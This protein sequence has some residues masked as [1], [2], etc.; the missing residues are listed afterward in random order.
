MMGQAYGVILY[1]GEAQQLAEVGF[2]REKLARYI[3][4]YKAIPWEEFDEDTQ[5]KIREIAE[6]GI[7]PGLTLDNCQPGGKIPV[8]NSN[9]LAI[10]VAGHMSGQT[11][12][13]KCMGSY[14]GRFGKVEGLNPCD[15]PF[16]IKKITGATLTK[17]GK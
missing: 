14:G 15:P 12:G 16:H 11:L 17:A 2:T 9:R 7:M 5:G 13:L 6:S 4:D 8:M 10:F 3:A 1:P